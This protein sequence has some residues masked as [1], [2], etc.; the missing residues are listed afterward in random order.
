MDDTIYLQKMNSL[1][2]KSGRIY[3]LVN[4]IDSEIYIGHTIRPLRKRLCEHIKKAQKNNHTRVYD[5]LSRVGWHNVS[6]V[7]IREYE[8]IKEIDLRKREAYYI[9]LAGTLN[10]QRPACKLYMDEY[11]KDELMY[12]LNETKNIMFNKINV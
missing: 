1:C 9:K 2:K 12:L 6:I 7:C 11:N 8:Y 4:R 3:A 5:H 10:S